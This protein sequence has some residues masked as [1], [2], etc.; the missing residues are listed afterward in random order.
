MTVEYYKNSGIDG[1]YI[2]SVIVM[3]VRSHVNYILINNVQEHSRFTYN[4]S[5][6]VSFGLVMFKLILAGLV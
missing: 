4:S 5:S 6:M 3:G 1:L 2:E